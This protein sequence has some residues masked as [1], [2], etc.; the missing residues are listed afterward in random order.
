MRLLTSN[1]R[2]NSLLPTSASLLDGY[3]MS[4]KHVRRF[5]DL[6]SLRPSF[7]S[8]AAATMKDD[9]EMVAFSVLDYCKGRE[10]YVHTTFIHKWQS[11]MLNISTFNI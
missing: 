2:R 9:E 5:E 8:A 1:K 10:R 3:K 11:E 4:V 7:A 6:L